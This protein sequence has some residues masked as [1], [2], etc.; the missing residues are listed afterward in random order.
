MLRIEKYHL[1]DAAL[2]VILLVGF[3]YPVDL[4]SRTKPKTR[5]IDSLLMLVN[6]GPDDTLKVSAYGNLCKELKNAG[7]Y[8][9]ALSYGSKGLELANELD[10]DRGKAL[11]GNN[12]GLVYFRLGNYDSSIYYHNI[13]LAARKE[14]NDTLS[15]SMAYNNLGIVYSAQ[16][17]FKVA[18]N[19]FLQSLEIKEKAGDKK[20]MIAGYGNLGVIYDQMRQYDTAISYFEKSF[21]LA[22]ELNDK[23]LLAQ[24]HLNIGGIWYKQ[25]VYEKALFHYRKV[26]ELF[27]TQS[28]T[29]EAATAHTNIGEVYS[30]TKMY[31][32]ASLELD[33]AINLYR[34]SNDKDGLPRALNIKGLMLTE[35]NKMKDALPYFGEAYEVSNETGNLIELSRAAH[36]LSVVYSSI[37]DFSKA[38]AYFVEHS[39]LEDS[40]YSDEVT[41][42]AVTAKLSYDYDKKEA[43]SKAEES[44]RER[45]RQEEIQKQK[46]LS[47]FIAGI[48]VMGMLLALFIFRSY[49]LK[50]RANAELDLK[51]KKIEQASKIIEV[52]NKEILDSINYAQR[53]QHAILPEEQTFRRLLPDAFVLYAPKDIVGGDFYYI[54]EGGTGNVFVA[55]ADCTGHGVP[56]AFMSLIC[57]KEMKLANSL[58]GSPGKI[59]SI[60]N[61]GVRNTLRQNNMDASKDGMDVALLRLGNG[62]VCFAGANRPLWIIRKQKNEIEEYKPTKCPIGGFVEDDQLYDNQTIPVSEGDQLYIFSDGYSDQFG[63]EKG[64][65]FTTK[66]LREILLSIRDL[67][68]AEQKA[69][70]RR[71]MQ[72][73]RGNIEQID[74][75]L[76]IGI[77]I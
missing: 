50:Q 10:H 76:I 24:S 23:P 22:T 5:N 42:A 61:R 47:W 52:K 75:Y 21:E 34:N 40:L 73:W 72:E 29:K 19:Y 43:L 46:M 53:I 32:M 36:G 64:K 31:E 35:Q 54:E 27:S 25:G 13:S 70:L 44:A 45:E 28:K 11:C 41:R 2:V 55:A 9:E 12:L 14:M 39:K 20:G 17:N 67:T 37:G 74:D 63:G 77:K 33:T 69:A 15:M 66:K 4:F 60:V 49:R 71:I 7:R 30:H 18:I 58:T 38:Y 48:A 56:G 62:E 68:A 16:G 59:L 65:K 51:N 6:S 1:R 26:L 8:S 57:S 3:I